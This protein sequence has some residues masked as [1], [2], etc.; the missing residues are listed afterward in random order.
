MSTARKRIHYNF[1]GDSVASDIAVLSRH[2]AHAGEGAL[3]SL[4]V[5]QI[6][7]DTDNAR[8]IG[9][10][11]PDEIRQHRQGVVD[12][13]QTDHPKRDFFEAL[14]GLASSIEK[15]GLLHPIVV[16]PIEGRYRMV[17][18]E[19]RYLAHLL[20]GR[21]FIRAL[22]RPRPSDT[23]EYRMWA[24][25][26]NLQREDLSVAEILAVVDILGSVVM[27]RKGVLPTW[28]DFADVLH[29]S[30]RQCG[31][32]ASLYRADTSIKDKIRSGEID[33]LREAIRLMGEPL[34]DESGDENDDDALQPLQPLQQGSDTS[35][36]RSS[37]KTRAFSLGRLKPAEATVLST[38]I[39]RAVPESC[40]DQFDAVDWHDADQA[41]DAWKAF[42]DIMIKAE[43]GGV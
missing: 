11:T 21:E 33:T 27:A 28:R 5:A 7:I 38:I 13:A 4:S 32:Y 30:K 26:E 8:F 31:Y 12:L 9:R 15:T 14:R 36:S 17:A 37:K 23:D 20:L 39:S 35:E 3:E 1:G 18:G 16:V 22:V 2:D 40:L 41:R 24:L 29:K 34:G 10:I 43:G 6:D 19:R 25:A 42:M